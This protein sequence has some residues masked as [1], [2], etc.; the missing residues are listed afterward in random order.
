MQQSKVLSSGG[1]SR[2]T[3]EARLRPEH[4]HLYPGVRAGVWESAAVVVDRIVAARLLYGQRMELQA[5]VLP[6]SHFEFRGGSEAG[7][8]PRREDR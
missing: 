4:A 7:N 5:R 1:P 3:W 6:E 2:L 8:R